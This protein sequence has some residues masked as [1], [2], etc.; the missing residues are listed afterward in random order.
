MNPVL[1]NAIVTF[2]KKAQKVKACEEMAELTKELCRD[3]IDQGDIEHIYEEIADVEIM[4]K[5]LRMIYGNDEKI[6][7]WKWLK[8]DRLAN[9]L[10]MD[11]LKYGETEGQKAPPH[12]EAI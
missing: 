2:G 3:I 6:D 4:L 12:L 7:N 10:A 8:L 1:V 5:Q 9:R 11:P